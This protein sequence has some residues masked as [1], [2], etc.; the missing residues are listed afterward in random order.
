[1]PWLLS[2]CTG[3]LLL[4]K[5]GLLKGQQATTHHSRLDLL[6]ALEPTAEVTGERVVDNGR[7]I[8]SA[9]IASGIDMSLHVLARMQG[10]AIAGAAA[11]YME[12]P[13]NPDEA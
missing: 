3:A 6:Q 7:I 9:G 2:V 13:W 4:A 10:S 5:A 1:M 8:L 11:R 12:Y